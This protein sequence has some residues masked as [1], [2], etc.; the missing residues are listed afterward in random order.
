M[1]LGIVGSGLMGG[2]LGTPIAR[3]GHEVVFGYA[4]TT[5]KLRKRARNAHGN[6]RAGTPGEAEKDADAIL[7][8]VRRSRIEEVP[9]QAGRSTSA[10]RTPS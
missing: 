8:A 3:A 1:R 5:Q 10:R 6:A 4:R 9:K 7:L 2:P